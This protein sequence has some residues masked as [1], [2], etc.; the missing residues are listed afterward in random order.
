M[1]LA[2]FSMNK[3]AKLV[4]IHCIPC[5]ELF[6]FLREGGIS[7]MEIFLILSSLNGAPLCSQAKGL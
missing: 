6:G 1:P 5:I 7:L 4:Q 3:G 2:K